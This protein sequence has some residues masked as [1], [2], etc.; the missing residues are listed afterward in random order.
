MTDLFFGLIVLALIIFVGRVVALWYWKVGV[1]VDLL[2]RSVALLEE[3]ARR[4]R[5]EYED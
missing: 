5:N 1:I 4:H 3:I 2:S